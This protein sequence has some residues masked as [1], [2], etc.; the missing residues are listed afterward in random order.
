MLR[1]FSWYLY[2][3]GATLT[4]YEDAP[5]VDELVASW[6]ESYRSVAPLSAEDEHAIP[7][8]LMLRRLMVSAFGMFIPGKC[9]LLFDTQPLQQLVHVRQRH[10]H[11]ARLRTLVSA[12]DPVLR[13]LVDDPPCPGV[14]D[15]ELALH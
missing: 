9:A 5:D 6:V 10:Q 8:F 7:T 4:V 3:L 15:V 12:D 11:L 13:E 2:D 1:S 14:A